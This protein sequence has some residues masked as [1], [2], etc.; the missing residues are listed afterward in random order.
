MLLL[1]RQ[2]RVR[3]HIS[4]RGREALILRGAL[5]GAAVEYRREAK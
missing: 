4:E 1:R 5:I 3:D 2:I